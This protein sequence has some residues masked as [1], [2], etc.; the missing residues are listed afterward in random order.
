MASIKPS[1][2]HGITDEGAD[3]AAWALHSMGYTDDSTIRCK[4]CDNFR[5]PDATRPSRCVG[6][7]TEWYPV[8]PEGHCTWGYRDA[9]HTKPPQK[10]VY[11]EGRVIWRDE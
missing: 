6:A 8:S 11:C 3:W 10:P 1:D 4:N 2:V 7:K 5:E 9:T